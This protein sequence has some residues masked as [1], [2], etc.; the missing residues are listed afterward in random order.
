[1]TEARPAPDPAI[2]IYKLVR[3]YVQS[4]T[5]RK[6]GITWD[7]I[8]DRKTK[9]D[10]GKERIDIPPRYREARESVCTDAFLRMRACRSRQD[11]IDYFT[12]TV[13]SVPQ[14][15]PSAAFEQVSVMLLDAENW[16][17]MKALAMLALSGLSRA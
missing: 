14:Y 17:D 9:S 2:M 12:G 4:R 6:S 11:F 8:K 1:M 7:S 3:A 13:C 5:E 15:L 10:D 16:E